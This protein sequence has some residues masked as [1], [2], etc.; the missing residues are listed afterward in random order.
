MRD[1]KEMSQE[2]IVT[3]FGSSRPQPS[4]ADYEEARELGAALARC[5]FAVCTGAY[6]GVME[7]ASRGAKENGGKTYGVVAEF[8]SSAKV[9]PW[10]D[11]QIRTQTW[12]ER[13]FDLVRL[14]DG[15]VACKG[16]TGT[17]VELA[18]VWEMMNKAVM[19]RKPFAVLGDF[20]IPVVERVRQVELAR[21]S[22]WSERNGQLIHQE[23]TAEA[24]AKFL[25]GKLQTDVLLR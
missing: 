22:P 16:G 6:G 2:R 14:G 15:Y 5:G 19:Q 9:N 21:A 11:V 8:F 1:Y 17:L 10:V 13:L 7:A 25:Q 20:W 3:V 12:Q 4:E 18:V 23:R 24:A